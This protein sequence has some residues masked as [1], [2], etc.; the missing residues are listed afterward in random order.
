MYRLYIFLS[1]KY[2]NLIYQYD[3]LLD[4]TIDSIDDVIST[5]AF[6][7]MHQQIIK[8][9]RRGMLKWSCMQTLL[10]HR[11]N[12]MSDCKTFMCW[13]V[14]AFQSMFDEQFWNHLV[15]S[16]V[17]GQIKF[18]WS[19]RKHVTSFSYVICIVPRN[20]ANGFVAECIHITTHVQQVYNREI[21]KINTSIYNY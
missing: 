11:V 5:V 16:S 3:K 12:S 9:V 15:R 6:Y 17:V 1:I 7:H 8:S 10:T 13:F 18:Q 20:G 2:L 21:D 14:E 19:V 4:I